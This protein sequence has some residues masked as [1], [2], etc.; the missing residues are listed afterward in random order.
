MLYI[1]SYMNTARSK[2]RLEEK[3]AAVKQQLQALGAMHPGSVS[4]QYQVCGRAGCRCMDP[5]QPQRHG[6][7][8][9]LA[10][11]YRGKPVCRF[12]RAD[13][14]TEVKQRL[15]TYKIF[16]ALMDQWIKLSIQQGADE[17]FGQKSA[18]LKPPRRQS[19][20]KH[21]QA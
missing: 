5:A 6:P 8:H 15:A 1:I 10:Y 19:R 11:V 20:S 3:I 9:K 7:Y 16:R 17:F 12:V 13:C 4:C 21:K 2:V 14:V 18:T